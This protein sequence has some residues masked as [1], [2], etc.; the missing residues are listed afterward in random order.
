MPSR[1]EIRGTLETV[2]RGVSIAILAWMLWLSLD[3]KTDAP[4]ESARSNGLSRSL[5]AWS[6]AGVAPTRVSVQLDST[7]RPIEREWLGALKSSGSEVGWTGSLP[8]VGIDVQPVASPRGGLTVLAGAPKGLGVRLVDDVGPL[9]TA[10]AVSGGARFFIPSAARRVQARVGASTAQALDADSVR[11]KRILVLGSAGWESKFVV[12]ALEEDGWK[13]DAQMR[14][15][16]GISVTQGSI[17][18]IDTSR[19]SAVIALDETAGAYASD[20]VRYVASGGG[21]VLAGSAAAIEGFSSIRPGA[22]GKQAGGESLASEPGSVTLRTLPL[23]PVVALRSDAAVLEKRE[24]A[25]AAAA[26]RHVAGRVLQVGY[27]DMWRWRM[28]GGDT[29]P[30]DHRAWWTKAVAGIAYA[31][32]IAQ[33][34]SAEAD[35]A[36]IASLVSTLGQPAAQPGSSLASTAASISLWWLFALLSASLLGEWASRR[37]R[38][39]R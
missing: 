14:V 19:Y 38:G 36:P 31:P 20:I 2:L 21:A 37:L 29:G 9:D 10:D 34:E 3:R 1:A 24:G 8:S 30:S 23:H 39:A 25:V 26:R 4:V 22:I 27:A 6:T 11:L 5:R 33:S 35:N 32:R 12:A 13:V 16:P 15:A 17:S 18:P 7:P 28:S